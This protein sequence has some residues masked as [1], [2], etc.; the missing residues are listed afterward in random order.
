MKP[1]NM[2]ELLDDP[3][4]RKF[5]MTIPRLSPSLAWGNPW[6]VWARKIDG[7]WMGGHFHTYRDAW[8]VVVKKV[9][10]TSFEDVA[11]VSKRQLFTTLPLGGH[12]WRI[13][14]GYEWCSRCRRPTS[15]AIRP[16][17]HALRTSPVMTTD[18]AYRCYFCGARRCL[19]SINHEGYAT[20]S[21]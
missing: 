15:Y 14:W 7:R 1:P 13:P 6:S 21:V 19:A 16:Q 17:H 18:D 4:Y 8:A 11:V 20:N 12:G 3:I 9:R 10:D 2:R 5:V